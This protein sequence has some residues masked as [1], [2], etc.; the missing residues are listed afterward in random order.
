MD[1]I[2]ALSDFTD[3]FWNFPEIVAVVGIAHKN[4]LATEGGDATHGGGSVAFSRDGD[5]SSAKIFCDLLGSIRTAVVGDDDFGFQAGFLQA[6]LS[7]AKAG[8]ES[9]GFVQAGDGNGEE[10]AHKF[11]CVFEIKI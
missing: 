11:R 7:F 5:D 8:S 2:E 4:V 10:R 3:E 6:S 1:K 9:I